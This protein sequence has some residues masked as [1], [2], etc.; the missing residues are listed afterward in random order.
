MKKTAVNN[1]VL[2]KPSIVENIS[3]FIG[4]ISL[5][6]FI[7]FMLF[8]MVDLIEWGIQEPHYSSSYLKVHYEPLDYSWLILSISC[9]G[10]SFNFFVIKKIL[11]YLRGIL[12]F[13][14]KD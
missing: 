11:E 1:S 4:L 6:A 8:F 7:I 13:N 12:F 10:I 9:A 2:Y 3:Q 14:Y 5:I